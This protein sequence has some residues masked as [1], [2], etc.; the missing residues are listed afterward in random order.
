MRRCVRTRAHTRTHA[1]THAHTHTHTHTRTHTHTHTLTHTH[2]SPANHSAGSSLTHCKFSHTSIGGL[3]PNTRKIQRCHG[4][5]RKIIRT[6][7]STHPP[8]SHWSQAQR[9]PWIAH[10]HV[11]VYVYHMYMYLYM[12]ITCICTCEPLVPGPALAMD[13]S[14]TE[15]CLSVK[16]SSSK[17]RP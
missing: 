4:Q 16:F 3:T 15:S 14:P 7:V 17:L 13:S 11:H 6:Y 10:A 12:Y 8:V 2:T 1:N 9:W 5:K